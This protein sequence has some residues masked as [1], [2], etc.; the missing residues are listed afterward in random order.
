MYGKKLTN[1]QIVSGNI[2]ATRAGSKLTAQLNKFSIKK[3]VKKD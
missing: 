2:K 1:E 3:E